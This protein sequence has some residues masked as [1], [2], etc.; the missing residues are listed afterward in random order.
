VCT[1]FFFRWTLR[2]AEVAVRVCGLR[3]GLEHWRSWGTNWRKLLN[4][5][6]TKHRLLY[7]KTQFVQ[8][9]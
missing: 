3:T 7:L 5:L 9:C 1:Q 8:R 6:K 2:A 4:P